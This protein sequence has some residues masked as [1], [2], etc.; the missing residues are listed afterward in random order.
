MRPVVRLVASVVRG[1]RVRASLACAFALAGV[2]LDGPD[3]EAPCGARAPGT[4]GVSCLATPGVRA[5][6]GGQAAA[7]TDDVNSAHRDSSADV[8]PEG[9]GVEAT[10]FG[11]SDDV[12][13]PATGATAA[14][15]SAPHRAR[16][17]L[18]RAARRCAL[19]DAGR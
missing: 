16:R 1:S 3:R 14:A 4:A 8:T 9:W 5:R 2:Q 13:C 10:M 12:P 17:A 18:H 11:R 19:M 6:P 7:G 15:E